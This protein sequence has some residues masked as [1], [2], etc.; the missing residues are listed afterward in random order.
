MPGTHAIGLHELQVFDEIAQ[1][2]GDRVR[3]KVVAH[4]SAGGHRF[5]IPVAVLGSDD[6]RSPA[7][8]Y[9]GG[10]HGLERVGSAVVLAHFRSIVARLGWDESLARQLEHLRMVYMPVVN[11]GGMW[12]RWRSNP[13]GVDLMR[14]G[15]EDA[16]G[17]VPWLV[18]GHR[19]GPRLPWYRGAVNAP[20]QSESAALCEVV[21]TELHS[22]RFSIALD[23][24]SGFGMIDRIWFPYAGRC[25]PIAD[26]PRLHALS[27][28]FDDA[29][30]HHRYLIEP[31]SRHYLAHG[32]LWDGLYDHALR[33]GGRVFLPMTLEMGSWTWIRKNPLQLLSR[34]GLFNPQKIRRTQRVMR[35]HTVW[36]DF[37]A[38]AA[39]NHERWLPDES[40]LEATRQSAITR[41]YPDGTR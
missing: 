15:P 36:L 29:H 18:G 30:P 8:G 6:P 21:R 23:C 27:S 33:D 20:M 16:R 37:V 7:V 4:V 25:E 3:R 24:H 11:P 40:E 38:Q 34:E 35:Q 12:M 13:A 5:P 26:L 22:H 32:D 31:Q 10:V 39:Y 19:I 17:R 2:A 41:W 9:F 28:L 14:N 1:R